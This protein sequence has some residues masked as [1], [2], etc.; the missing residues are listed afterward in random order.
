VRHSRVNDRIIPVTSIGD[1]GNS[2]DNILLRKVQHNSRVQSI[3]VGLDDS[4]AV[5]GCKIALV[6]YGIDANTLEDIAGKVAE[7]E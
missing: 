6:E 2:Q 1:V 5:D 4:R 7:D 3:D